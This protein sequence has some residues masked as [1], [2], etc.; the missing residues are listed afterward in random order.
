MAAQYLSTGQLKRLKEHKYSATGTS[1]CEP[2]MQV[3]WRWL[4][5]QI[6]TTWAPNTITLV[7]LLINI[8]TTLILVFYSP[9]GQQEVRLMA[10]HVTNKPSVYKLQIN[11]FSDIQASFHQVLSVE[12]I[13]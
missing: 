6:P 3:F 11:I 12:T 13:E 7:G 1:I 8:F 9:D 5:E 4:V 2:T 10:L